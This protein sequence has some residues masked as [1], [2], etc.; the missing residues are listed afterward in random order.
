MRI[1]RRVATAAAVAAALILAAP[2]AAQ[3]GTG[4]EYGDHIST[5]AQTMGFTGSHNP[6]VH[7]HG[8][9]GWDGM[10]CHM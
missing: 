5:C 10:P 8:Y 1:A 7:H 2:A 6:G 4:A 3:A 9:A